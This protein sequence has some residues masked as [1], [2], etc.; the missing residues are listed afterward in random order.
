[1]VAPL[2][3]QPFIAG[4]GPAAGGTAVVIA[5]DCQVSL[6]DGVTWVGHRHP[7]HMTDLPRLSSD[8]ARRDSLRVHVLPPY[9]QKHTV[10]F[11]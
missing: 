3:L 11:F 10:P 6:R 8:P 9:T 4:S 2:S 5:G 7:V 1:M